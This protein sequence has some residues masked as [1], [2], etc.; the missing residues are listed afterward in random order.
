MRGFTGSQRTTGAI[1]KFI[2]T[3]YDT[4]KNVHDNLEEILKVGLVLEYTSDFLFYR[5][6]A[7]A[8]QTVFTGSDLNGRSLAI[9]GSPLVY[10]NREKVSGDL[11]VSE[12]SGTELRFLD[13]LAEGDLVY[14]A[15]FGFNE[16]GT[17]YYDSLLSNASVN[18]IIIDALEAKNVAV[19]SAEEAALSKTTTLETAAEVTELAE[20]TVIIRNELFGLT[21][22]MY[23]LPF[24]EVGYAT[25]TAETGNL[26]VFLPEG[27]AGPT[28]PEGAQ[29]VT[30]STGSQ[31]IQ[32]PRGI[33]GVTGDTGAVGPAG[34]EGPEG[35]SGAS[36][37]I[38][39]K[40]PTGDQGPMGATPLGLA[41]G[42]FFL[43]EDGELNIEYYGDALDEDFTIDAD[44]NLHVTTG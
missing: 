25:Y 34:P 12:N 41:F 16:N 40:G 17:V 6:E 28:G 8:G 30:G 29:G 14:I 24:G 19:S 13:P 31:G 43:N 20:Q 4:I 35:P 2:G 1:D 39:D 11:V 37:S 38:G 18:Q 10:L 23:R 3:S 32:G 33:Q 21:V 22:E 7:S 36:G 44:G 15:S 26:D 9:P 5:F 27:P 42:R